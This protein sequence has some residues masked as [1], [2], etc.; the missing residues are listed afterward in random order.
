MTTRRVLV[1]DDNRDYR[2]A[3]VDALSELDGVEVVA[4][5]T[6][7]ACLE[8]AFGVEEAVRMVLIDNTLNHPLFQPLRGGWDMGPHDGYRGWQFADKLR[9]ERPEIAVIAFSLSG[10]M[11]LSRYVDVIF[12]KKWDLLSSIEENRMAAKE[13]LRAMVMEHLN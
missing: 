8:I 7:D 1:V 5:D 6:L 13:A 9:R 10:R 3:A 4:P 12:G 11:A 2:E